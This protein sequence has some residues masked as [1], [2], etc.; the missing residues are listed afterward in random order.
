MQSEKACGSIVPL[1]ARIGVSWRLQ[2]FPFLA[3]AWTSL[4]N[5]GACQL[6]ALKRALIQSCSSFCSASCFPLLSKL[7]HEVL[8]LQ[9]QPKA[10]KMARKMR[11]GCTPYWM[12]SSY[13]AHLGGN[14]T[15]RRAGLLALDSSQWQCRSTRLSPAG[16]IK[17]PPPILNLSED[18]EFQETHLSTS[19]STFS[20]RFTPS[21]RPSSL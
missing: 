11:R 3:C 2:L 17:F 1:T 9:E 6:D 10:L 8:S 19:L 18:F 7:P 12:P 20:C 14:A 13:P 16:L 5:R 4:P 21:I 15:P